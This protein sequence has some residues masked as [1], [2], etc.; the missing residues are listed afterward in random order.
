MKK[1]YAESTL[2]RKYRETGI[3][4]E[5]LEK[6]HLY[7]VA[8]AHF[9]KIISVDEVWK[10]IERTEARQGKKEL[11]EI[12]NPSM[13]ECIRNYSIEEHHRRMQDRQDED[14]F[15]IT[16]LDF[17]NS[18]SEAQGRVWARIE[19]KLM[20]GVGGFM[21][22]AKK[23]AAPLTP[24]GFQYQDGDYVL[25]REDFDK[26][27]AIKERSCDRY[28]VLPES[29]FYEDGDDDRLFLVDISIML[30]VEDGE[31]LDFFLD[32]AVEILDSAYEKP[33][34]IPDDLLCYIDDFYYEE[35]TETDMMKSFL[36]KEFFSDRSDE[37]EEEEDELQSLMFEINRI[38]RDVTISPTGDINR[39]SKMLDDKGYVF[40]GFDQ[41]ERFI[42]LYMNLANNTRLPANKG[43]TP[44]ELLPAEGMGMPAKIEFGPGIQNLLR[45][46]EWDPKEMKRDIMTQANL[47]I[48]LRGD[49][50]REVDRALAPGEERVINATG[51]IVKGKKIKPNEPCPCGSGRKYKHCCGRRL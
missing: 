34:Y 33:V 1:P 43:H 35:T 25:S 18:D 40:S 39:V 19:K 37:A 22:L 10:V 16:E 21:D 27:I 47:P 6:L 9:Y 42:H 7:F 13:L 24:K 11:E 15:G 26:V 14:S 30:E 20:Q 44:E 45:S 5:V 4:K 3:P 31:I 29:D 17:D 32:D 12:L 28:F 51:T 48:E 50:M 8:C 2:K 49:M 23:I 41:V 38:V 36:R 46:G